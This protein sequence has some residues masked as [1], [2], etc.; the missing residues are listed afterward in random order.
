MLFDTH[1]HL[2]FSAY[3]DD[4]DEVVKKTQ[5]EN[6]WVINVGSNYDNS[7]LAIDIAR[8]YEQ[9]VYA[10]IGLHPI[11]LAGD[12]FKIKK[13]TNEQEGDE[14]N[15]DSLDIDK[16]KKLAL[17]DSQR[18]VAIGEIGLD[19]YYRP[20]TKTKLELFKARQKEFFIKQLN[21][22][23]ELKLPVIFHCR[24]AHQDLIAILEKNKDVR[25]V[26]HCFTGTLEDAKKYVDMGFYIG[27]NGIIFKLNLDEIIKQIPLES[28]LLE[29]DCPYLT[30]P[31][32]GNER[33]EPIFVKYVARRIAEL[34]SLDYEK[35]AEIT[36]QNARE[37][38]RI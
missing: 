30:P 1:A 38:F 13:D 11:H 15:K 16:Y 32:E 3:K 6:V 4:L 37:L 22:A 23:K 8:K 17:S 20:K 27:L 26:I 10:A 28:I 5:K 21:L 35:V 18:V 14:T 25:G 24:M 7:K 2:N 29:T 34:K 33:N 31:Q 36:A 9:G 12:F 19:Y